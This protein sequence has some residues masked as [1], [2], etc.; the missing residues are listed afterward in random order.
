[1]Y[2]ITQAE[3]I[4]PVTETC[5]NYISSLSKATPL[6]CHEYYEFFLITKGS[7]IHRVNGEVQHLTEGSL[8]F[9]RPDDS[10]SY[11]Y[12]NSSDCSFLNL[13]C[14]RRVIDSAFSYIGSPQLYQNVAESKLPPSVMIG[15]HDRERFVTGFEDI[16][17][18]CTIDKT[19]ANILLRRMLI[20]LLCTCYR[21]LGGSP[22]SG[23]P[24]WFAAL[25]TQMQRKENF[26]A[27]LNRM[28]ELSGYSRGHLDRV[29]RRFLGQ[30]P[31][32][33]VNSLRL[34]YVKSLLQLTDLPITDIAL[35]AG[36][37]N[38]SHFNHLFR[39]FYGSAPTTFRGRRR[40]T[41]SVDLNPG[42]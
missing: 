9:I 31:V 28:V 36:F 37:E 7:C 11:E 12:E 10:H 4:D 3:H 18:L 40:R 38:I 2:R 34:D 13:P 22:A 19:Q 39:R 21:S 41:G 26:S 30:K 17:T 27:G 29:F 20:D 32:D 14:S 25:L 1:M 8:V 35:D 42:L 23:L 24:G 15:S 6:H 33:Y 5:P 16:R